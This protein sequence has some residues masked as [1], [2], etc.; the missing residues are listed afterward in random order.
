MEYDSMP[1]LN[2]FLKEILRYY[3]LHPIW[4]AR[5]P[6]TV[7]PDPLASEITTTSGEAF[8]TFLSRRGSSFQSLL[9]LTR[10]AYGYKFVDMAC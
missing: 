9:P 5:L 6:R 10:G 1:F 8:L 3:P 4:S 2:A 7:I